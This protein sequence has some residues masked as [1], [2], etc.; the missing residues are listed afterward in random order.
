MRSDL[1][2]G[3]SYQLLS[4][5][6]R[7]VFGENNWFNAGP[8]QKFTLRSI[9]AQDYAALP[10]DVRQKYDFSMPIAQLK[11]RLQFPDDGLDPGLI[12][13]YG[14]MVAVANHTSSALPY[15]FRAFALRPNDPTISLS[16]ATMYVSSAMKRQTQN[17]QYEIHQ[18]LSFLYRYYDLRTSQT[19]RTLER[20]EAEYNVARMWHGIGLTHLAVP[21]Y[22]KVLA[23]SA[24]VDADIQAARTLQEETKEERRAL[25]EARRDVGADAMG[26]EAEEEED[27]EPT[28]ENFATEAAYALQTLYSFAGNHAAAKKVTDEFLV[29]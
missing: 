26:K 8:T 5:V 25:R 13:N 24:D 12:M 1:R 20:Q 29:L 7:I 22:E 6:S 16:I 3:S 4:A 27:D 21:G 9:K 18:G 11:R 15:Y 14:H 19:T 28:L 10:P 23:M 2:S 17:R